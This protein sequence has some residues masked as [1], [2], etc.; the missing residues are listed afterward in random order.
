MFAASSTRGPHWSLVPVRIILIT[1]LLTLLALAVGLLI[2]IVGIILMAK[3]R[4]LEPD[5]TLAYRFIAL[6]AAMVTGAMT[7]TAATISE[8]RAYRR[9][10]AIARLEGLSGQ[11]II[12]Q[13]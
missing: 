7:L 8:I 13:R 6:P 5:M 9:N 2:G 3:L 11:S 10:K 12:Q 1:L 4:G